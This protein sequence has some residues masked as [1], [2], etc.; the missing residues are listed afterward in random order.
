MGDTQGMQVVCRMKS[1]SD[2][3]L[4][5]EDM[6]RQIALL[7]LPET[8][9]RVRSADETCIVLS[10]KETNDSIC[11]HFKD[12]SLCMEYFRAMSIASQLPA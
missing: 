4:E 2:L 8:F 3:L 1:M 10:S 5:S 7:H 9:V 6:S 12:H 11:L